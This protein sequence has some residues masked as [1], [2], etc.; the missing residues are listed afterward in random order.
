[1]RLFG[2]RVCANAGGRLIPG[3]R[4]L[5]TR[6]GGAARAHERISFSASGALHAQLRTEVENFYALR[7][8]PLTREFGLYVPTPCGGLLAKRAETP[9]LRC[10]GRTADEIAADELGVSATLAAMPAARAASLAMYS[11]DS[12]DAA[13]AL[14]YRLLLGTEMLRG[15]WVGDAIERILLAC[16]SEPRSVPSDWLRVQRHLGGRF[17]AL[18]RQTTDNALPDALVQEL[19]AI[20]DT[21]RSALQYLAAAHRSTTTLN[22]DAIM[23]AAAAAQSPTS[24]AATAGDKR[25]PGLLLGVLPEVSAVLTASNNAI[26]ALFLNPTEMT[27]VAH[28]VQTHVVP[29]L[30]S[31][32]AKLKDET[33]NYLLRVPVSRW[34]QELWGYRLVMLVMPSLVQTCHMFDQVLD[35][36]TCIRVL[37]EL[38][39]KMHELYGQGAQGRSQIGARH[40]PLPV[41]IQAWVASTAERL[42]QQR[43]V[44]PGRMPTV[45]DGVH[46]LTNTAA[47]KAGKNGNF[48][49]EMGER[50][51]SWLA[52]LDQ[53]EIPLSIAT[54]LMPLFGATDG[55]SQTAAEWSDTPPA[56]YALQ[57]RMLRAASAA[58]VS[59]TAS[60][61]PR[62]LL[63]LQF[64]DRLNEMLRRPVHGA[65]G[66]TSDEE[67][68]A[69]RDWWQLII[70]G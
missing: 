15:K 4:A 5:A 48:F 32:H 50:L 60:W 22:L 46:L 51:L 12:P 64:D 9:T 7:S 11:V 56:L 44:L 34:I 30:A 20:G 28:W 31:P 65:F 53:E 1:M 33:A 39:D 23:R 24:P 10:S 55:L 62:D 36:A 63:Y 38:A 29:V 42:P 61:M 16:S 3:T 2:K 25:M 17:D 67:Q 52:L 40:E 8:A 41:A 18:Q 37:H 14:T 69:A 70:R 47:H 59:H 6:V 68:A 66:Y 26:A 54:L 13:K 27:H 21:P 43:W 57:Q 58:D 35:Q 49:A 45:A 19:I